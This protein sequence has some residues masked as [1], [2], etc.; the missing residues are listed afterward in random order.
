MG[1]KSPE[2]I[3]S[4]GKRSSAEDSCQILSV[5]DSI[6]TFHPAQCLLDSVL[7]RDLSE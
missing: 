6:C 1:T 4:K 2:P 3:L 5:K 7:H